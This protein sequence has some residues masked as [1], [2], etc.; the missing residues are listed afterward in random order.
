[1]KEKKLSNILYIFGRK[2]DNV[3]VENSVRDDKILEKNLLYSPH[4]PVTHLSEL[5]IRAT[6]VLSL[7]N[8]TSRVELNTQ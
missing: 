5:K 4:C 2:S 7:L 8:I 6:L 1:M 3:Y